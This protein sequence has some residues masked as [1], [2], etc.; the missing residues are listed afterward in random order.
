MSTIFERLKA[1]VHPRARSVGF[2]TV[3]G[4]AAV[5][6][7]LALHQVKQHWAL[8][9][10]PEIRQS[11]SRS[12]FLVDLDNKSTERGQ[13]IGF[14]VGPGL[15][16]YAEGTGFMK[17]LVGLPG[18]KLSVTATA[19][20]VNGVKVAGPLDLTAELD[21]PAA[22]FVRSETIPAGKLFV[23]GTQ[24]KSYDSRYWGYVDTASVVGRGWPLW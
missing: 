23:V 19:T 10:S 24:P 11:L 14:R 20:F 2:W 9:Y 8:T 21:R 5:S 1:G 12:T 22:D 7:V 4:V 16:R 13:F 6:M 15:V 17:V 18:D 3:A